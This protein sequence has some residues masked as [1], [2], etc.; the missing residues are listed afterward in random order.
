M[1]LRIVS[2]LAAAIIGLLTS[3][4]PSAAQ[5]N[6]G[7]A[8]ADEYFGKFQLSVLG[9]A[10]TI[11]DAGLRAESGAAPQTM[12]D[13]PLA[14]ATDAIKAWESR[15]PRDPWIAKDLL[16]LENV[17]LRLPAGAGLRLAEKTEAWLVSDYPSTSYAA[18]GRAQIAQIAP[19]AANPRVAARDPRDDAGYDAR[20]D[21]RDFGG[22]IMSFG[23]NA[24]DPPAP[25][26]VAP[27]APMASTLPPAHEPS[28]AWMRFAALRAPLAAAQH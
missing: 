15:Y 4:A 20:G 25:V 14:F 2:A 1:H 22:S 7:L 6:A 19:G 13:G 16:A 11:R 9:I 10:N 21:A 3:L 17:E 8:P 12:I 23:P 24:A 18:T 28:N 5:T 26:A 27:R